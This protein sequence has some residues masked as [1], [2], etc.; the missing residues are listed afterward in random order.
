[1]GVKR[2]RLLL[3]ACGLL[4]LSPNIGAQPPSRVYRVGWIVAGPSRRTQ[5]DNPFVATFLKEMQSLGFAEGRNL[6]FLLRGVEGDFARVDDV[7]REL[8]LEKVDVIYAGADRIARR[9]KLLVKSTPVVFVSFDPV[10][11]G[12]VKSLARPGSNFTGVSLSASAA[13]EA[14]RLEILR[15]VLPSLRR[16]AFLGAAFEW[17]DAFSGIAVRD[18]A[19]SS[20]IELWQAECGEKEVASG[21]ERIARAKPDAAFIPGSIT[22]YIFRRQIGEFLH[23]HRIPAVFGFEESVE[24]GGL[25]SYGADLED[26]SRKIAGCVAKILNGSSPATLP[27]E[28][29]TLFRMAINLRAA[30]ELGIAVPQSVLLRADRVIE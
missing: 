4:G 2:R 1:M 12:Y 24:A 18:A 15:E 10:R 21:L 14:K 27:V 25:L 20:G 17:N 26:V 6:V 5:P 11:A 30:R 23:E 28:Q 9:L 19:R 22:M 16:V 3:A 13:L 8:M 29:P 7:L